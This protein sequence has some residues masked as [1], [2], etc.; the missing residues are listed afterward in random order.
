[1]NNKT[2]KFREEFQLGE[3]K[4]L[5]EAI[6]LLPKVSYSKFV[7]SVDIDIQLNLKESQKKESL[8]GSV[9]LPHQVGEAQKVIVFADKKEADDAKKAGAVE[10]GLDDLIEKVINGE[11]EYDVVIA[12]PAVMPKIAKL[13]KILGPKGLMPNPQNGTITQNVVEAVESFKSGRVNFRM[14]QEQG[15]VRGRVAKLDMEPNQI[16]DNIL[17]FIRAVNSEAKKFSSNPIKQV[18]LKPTM[19]A[20]IRVDV[21]DIMNQI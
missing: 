13:G 17:S 15:T 21:Y 18:V 3:L 19:G 14:T 16:K 1:M 12:T 8:R 5:D 2:K 9:S 20:S 6:S 11:V 10:A 7:G 4:T